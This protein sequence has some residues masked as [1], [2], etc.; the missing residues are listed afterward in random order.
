[1]TLVF[2]DMVGSTRLSAANELEDFSITL[3]TFHQVVQKAIFSYGGAVVQ[4]YGDGLMACFGQDT[5]T[6]DGED[7]AVAAV[8]ASLEIIKSLKIVLPEIET[9][10]GVHS[11][12]VMAHNRT[13]SQLSPTITGYHANLAAHLQ[14]EATPGT[15][16]ISESTRAFISRLVQADYSKT[17]VFY[18]KGSEDPISFAEIS[19]F[20]FAKSP[21]RNNKFVERDKIIGKILGN[22]FDDKTSGGFAIIGGPG[23]GKSTLLSHL[24]RAVLDQR[25]PFT[26]AARMSLGRTPFFP[27]T[28]A[29]VRFLELDK[30]PTVEQI[31]TA[32]LSKDLAL[33][34]AQFEIFTEILGAS[35]GMTQT[36]SPEQTLTRATVVLADLLS[37]IGKAIEAPLFFDDFHW[38]DQQSIQTIQLALANDNPP[39]IILTARP[40]QSVFDF[41]NT[42]TLT[43][44]DLPPLSQGAAERLLDYQ[45]DLTPFE[46]YTIIKRAEGNPLFL[47]ALAEHVNLEK[48]SGQAHDLPETIEATLQSNISGLGDRKN[49]IQNAAVIGRHFTKNH[50]MFLLGNSSEVEIEIEFLVKNGT[51]QLDGIGYRFS[52][53]LVRDAA[54]NMLSST[55][56]RQLHAKYATAIQLY[57]P[58]FFSQYPGLVADHFYKASEW[59]SFRDAAIAA[60][61]L[62]IGRADFESAIKY[63]TD[64]LDT[65]DKLAQH[66][67]ADIA[68]GLTAQT[69]LSNA[70]VQKFGFAHPTVLQTYQ[71][72]EVKT[73]NLAEFPRERIYALY[74]LF[75]HKTIQGDLWAARQ[76]AQRMGQIAI[77][78]DNISKLLWL[79][80][81]SACGLY[82][83]RFDQS[84]QANAG[85][86]SFYDHA[87]HDKLFLEIGADPLISIY[88]AELHI[89]AQRGE[90]KRAISTLELALEHQSRI[91]AKLQ[92]PWIR[93]F[94]A[95]AL[96]FTPESERADAEIIEGI[97]VAD[98]QGA[99]FWSLVGR[100]LQGVMLIFRGEFADGAALVNALAPKA[101]AVGIQ[102]NFPLYRAAL[103]MAA[104]AQNRPDQAKEHLN[105]AVYRIAKTGEGKWAALIW[106]IYEYLENEL[107]N[108]LNSKKAGSIASSYARRGR[109][110]IWENYNISAAFENSISVI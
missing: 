17:G 89:H 9:R 37:C 3:S 50:L 12:Q 104:I 82:M 18:L 67:D 102:I 16:V 29:I 27:I 64:A 32:L 48:S 15:V 92:E 99:M 8:A 86:K 31:Q 69:L 28:E 100:M 54:Y 4:A 78:Q 59:S 24:E 103:A 51:F 44:L 26:M 58:E 81:Q 68:A 107:Q 56:R 60:G 63:L 23:L 76:M 87:E 90:T 79:V 22:R 5:F 95:L 73:R 97:E 70:Q 46:K 52:H 38:A 6:R 19:K 10:V 88:S 49:L 66:S 108:P 98:R 47:L 2:V 53:A 7:A 93:C 25:I 62:A 41:L 39:E 110:V 30:R 84:V 65:I 94:S 11:G 83:G 91:G 40:T 42:T 33:N 106:K 80:N 13:A 105:W 20:E 71:E 35:S 72:L 21:G 45:S 75:A 14:A 109:S 1:M 85:V 74:G 43:K 36:V 77:E 96:S 55:T 34:S 61:A 101:E 57:D